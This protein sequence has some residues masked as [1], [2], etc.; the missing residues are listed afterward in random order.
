M[1]ALQPINGQFSKS[2]CPSN[3]LIQIR[4]FWFLIH[5]NE[6]SNHEALYK[7]PANQFFS[8]GLNWP[9]MIFCFPLS[10]CQNGSIKTMPFPE[11]QK[12]KKFK[13]FKKKLLTKLFRKISWEQLIARTP[14]EVSCGDLCLIVANDSEIR[15]ELWWAVLCRKFPVAARGPKALFDRF[16]QRNFQISNLFCSN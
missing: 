1:N 8:N 3:T 10:C 12:E 5:R 11:Q 13:K 6:R 15:A 16:P 14:A 2:N 4:S 7:T 9:F